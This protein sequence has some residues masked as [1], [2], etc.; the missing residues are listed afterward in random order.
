[1]SPPLASAPRLSLHDQ[2]LTLLRT[3]GG[4]SVYDGEVGSRPPVIPDRTGRVRPYV[5]LY[6]GTGRRSGD[7]DLADVVSDAEPTFQTT[8]VAGYP[9]D[10]LYLFDRLVPLLER[11]APDLASAVCSSPRLV[12]D[13]GSVRRDDDTTPPRF[14][15][16][17]LWRLTLST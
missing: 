12:T 13:P 10:L 8:A 1:M 14:Y 2:T 4:V 6:A 11:W 7:D 5:V 15:L 16:P 3:L 17:L 9:P